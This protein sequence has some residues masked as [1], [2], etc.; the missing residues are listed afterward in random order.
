[1]VLQVQV[2]A[3]LITLAAIIFTFAKAGIKRNA[4]PAIASF[5]IAALASLIAFAGNYVPYGNFSI[6]FTGMLSV[7]FFAMTLHY[8]SDKCTFMLLALVA[9]MQLLL[10]IVYSAPLG[11]MRIVA[12]SFGVGTGI[13]FML[14]VANS[15]R[16]AVKTDKKVEI[17]RD[18]FQILIGIVVILLLLL[19]KRKYIAD[20]IILA[21][22][23][24]GY[25]FNNMVNNSKR[26]NGF[27]SFFA[28]LERKGALY[29]TGATYAA[30]GL[31]LLIG[32][33]P[34][35][36]FLSLGCV[37]LFFGDSIA[38]LVGKNLNTP[39]LPYNNLK[40]VWGTVAFFAV[41]AVLGYL[42]IGIYAVPLALLL[43]L[44]E[45]AGTL[46]DDNLSI[47]IV[48]AAVYL[49]LSAI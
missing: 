23:L 11:Y 33:V 7:L 16:K 48:T 10:G 30:A 27:K 43:A 40:S 8:R 17:T 39:R 49:F 35:I 4:L 42:L 36:G 12:L 26:R 3:T 9:A 34:N 14:A 19:L 44:V 38:T 41:T 24:I 28:G 20:Y 15:P 2:I 21:M 31:G 29:G 32:L 45:S 22:I 6:L 47:P 46:L 37:A 5:V 1:M 25:S 18:L 13:G